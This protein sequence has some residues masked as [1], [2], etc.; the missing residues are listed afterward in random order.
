MRLAAIVESSD[1]AII[2]VDLNGL[3]TSWNEG[4]QRLLGYAPREIIGRPLRRLLP[5]E[6]AAD[7][8]QM[9][10]RVRRGQSVLDRD[11]VRI[12]S[13]GSPVDVSV[14]VSPIRDVTGRIIGA[15]TIA[16]DITEI[17]RV[18]GHLRASE[19]RTGSWPRRCRSSSGGCGRTARRNT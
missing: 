7:C 4:A 14:T 15:A 16:R 12:R 17:K 6:E 19:E 5:A 18:A 13:D 8:D 1:D 9:L 2:A 10:A 3:V 11:A